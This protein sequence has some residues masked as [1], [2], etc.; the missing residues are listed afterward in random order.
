VKGVKLEDPAILVS[1]GR[2]I[3]S[4]QNFGMVRELA[5]VLGGA[6]DPSISFAPDSPISHP[7]II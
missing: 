7:I 5:R 4:D 6:A 2:G 1:G 3:G